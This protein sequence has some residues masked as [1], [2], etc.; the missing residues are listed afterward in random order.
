MNYNQYIKQ[1]TEFNKTIFENLY[2]S[3]TMVME[4][5]ESMFEKNFQKSPWINDH[6]IKMMNDFINT[7]KQSREGFKKAVDDSFVRFNE[8]LSPATV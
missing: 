7:S 8:L 3:V 2:T 4:Q 6:L 1:M 5:I